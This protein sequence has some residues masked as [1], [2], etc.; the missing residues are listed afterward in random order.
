MRTPTPSLLIFALSLIGMFPASADLVAHWKLDEGSGTQAAD[1]SPNNRVGTVSDGATWTNADLPPVPAGTSAALDLDGISGQ[2]DIVGYKG[3]TGT[4]DRSVTAWIR[5]RQT[6]TAQN[7][8]IVSW[9]EN[10]GTNK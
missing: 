5:T 4:Q 6:T 3:V 2:V 7:K 9:G 10:V 1:S 8:G